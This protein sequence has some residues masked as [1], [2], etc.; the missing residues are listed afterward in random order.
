[1]QQPRYFKARGGLVR[2]KLLKVRAEIETCLSETISNRQLADCV[3]LSRYH[4]ARAFRQSTGMSPQAYVI[5][6]R[7]ERAVQ[8]MLSTD[9][10][11]R[12]RR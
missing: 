3:Q 1:M 4:F 9:A 5:R 11:L 2:W 7:I 10:P 12:Y 6:R 8:L